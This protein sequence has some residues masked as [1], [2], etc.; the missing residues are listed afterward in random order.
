MTDQ[1]GRVQS[2]GFCNYP[3]PDYAADP[4]WERTADCPVMT[5]CRNEWPCAAHPPDLPV[6]AAYP[7]M[8]SS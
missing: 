7:H 5:R 2:T 3:V 4:D 1:S 8:K 6:S